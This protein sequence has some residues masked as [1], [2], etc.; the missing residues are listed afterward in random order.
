MKLTD[1]FC[2]RQLQPQVQPAFRNIPGDSRGSVSFQQL[3]CCLHTHSQ[4]RAQLPGISIIPACDKRQDCP[5][6]QQRAAEI[7]R[8]LGSDQSGQDIVSGGYA[9]D[10]AARRDNFA[11]A[12]HIDYMA[13]LVH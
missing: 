1:S 4:C 7:A 11:E 3:H 9:G 10:P 8:R 13:F 2:T 5:L 6:V 12:F